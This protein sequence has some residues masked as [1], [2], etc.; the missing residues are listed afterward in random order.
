MYSEELKVVSDWKLFYQ[1]IAIDQLP[2]KYVDIF[3]VIYN[4]E[5]LSSGIGG[6]TIYKEK[7]QVCRELLSEEV[8]KKL[9]RLY[10]LEQNGFVTDIIKS[11]KWIYNCFRA[12]CKVGRVF[13]FVKK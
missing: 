8:V 3:V 10:Y 12:F 1:G 7:L 6:A 11:K 4:M 13:G 9:I 5:G 2:V